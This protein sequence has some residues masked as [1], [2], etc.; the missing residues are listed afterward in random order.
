M[1]TGP[2]EPVESETT[3]SVESE[4]NVAAEAHPSLRE[5]CEARQ[6]V[7]RAAVDRVADDGSRT[8]RDIEA[9]LGALDERAPRPRPAPAKR[10]WR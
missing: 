7:L 1:K 6:K 2:M 10:S 4:V 3:A 8:R 5:Q 9:A